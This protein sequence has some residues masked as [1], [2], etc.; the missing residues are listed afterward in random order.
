V[1]G[2]AIKT[3]EPVLI[4][5][6]STI[7]TPVSES[8]LRETKCQLAVPIK[9]SDTIVGVLDLQNDQPGTLTEED[10][11][12]MI[13]LC[14][15]IA[16]A[17]RNAELL[18]EVQKSQEA[19]QRR[20]H[21]LELSSGVSEQLTANLNLNDLLASV[22]SLI[23]GG[24]DYYHVHVYLVEEG[25][26]DLLMMEGTGEPGMIMKERGH[27]IPAGRGLVGTAAATG[28]TV[29]VPDVSKAKGWLP[30][31]LLPDTKSELS[32]PFKMGDE[33]I[34]V[35]DVQ[36]DQVGGL[37]EEDQALL[38]GLG[39]QI[40]VAV[41][42]AR[43]FGEI[44]RQVTEQT[45]EIQVFQALAENA[46]DAV[47]MADLD[48]KLF[49]ANRVW[50]NLYRYDAA[51]GEAVGTSVD[52]VWAPETCAWMKEAI[53]QQ[54]SREWRGQV[55][56]ELRDGTRLTIE[57][58]AFVVRDQNENPIAVA[59]MGRDITAARLSDELTRLVS[60]ASSQSE[61]GVELLRVVL[62]GMNVDC[63]SF[64]I[65]EGEGAPR[66]RTA[67]TVAA[68]DDRGKAVVNVDQ[69]EP[70]DSDPIHGEL[71]NARQAIIYNDLGELDEERRA[72]LEE[73]GVAAIAAL[74]LI[75][76]AG[77]VG[78]ALLLQ[79]KRD[80][81]FGDEIA[82]LTP[83]LQQVSLAVSNLIFREAQERETSAM[84]AQRTTEMQLTTEV[85]QA[86][87]SAIE[88]DDLFQRVVTLVREQF[89][90][91]HVHVYQHDPAQGILEIAAGYGEP[92]RIMREQGH[93]IQVGSGLTG[94]AAATGEPVLASDV[95]DWENW[96]PNPL[97][98][99][100]KSEVAV[101]IKMG[102]EVLGV[103]DVQDDQVGALT[104]DTQV[105]LQGLCGQIAIAIQ[106]TR[107]L[108]ETQASL[109]QTD[110]LLSLST[111]LSSLTEPQAIADA[112]AEQLMN[113]ANIERCSVTLCSEYDDQ[114]VPHTAQ[115]YALNDRDP[116]GRDAAIGHSYA[117]TAF[118]TFAKVI[119]D[120]RQVLA[121][122]DLTTDE[123]LADG[124]RTF[125]QQGGA[126]S[127]IVVP[128]VSGERVVGYFTLQDR[129][130]YTFTESE[131]ELYRGIASQSATAF[132]NALSLTEVQETLDEV[133]MLY[134]SSRAISTANTRE[135]LTETVV[136]RI[137]STNV[138]HCEIL[139]YEQ[140]DLG[141]RYVE[142]VGSWSLDG[143]APAPDTR[144][145]LKEYALTEVAEQ[146]ADKGTR[147]ITA[148]D[149]DQF[150][151]VR[152]MCVSRGIKALALVPLNVGQEYLGFLVIE[153]HKSSVFA[154]DTLRF[155]E[156]V[157]SQSAVALR[158]IQLIEQTQQQLEQLQ[159]S[160]DDA[161]RLADTVRELSSPVI[162]VWEDVLVLPLVG[163]I[164]SRRALN[165]ME[166]LLTGITEYQA[167]Q[168]IIDITGVPVM[169][170]SVANYLLQTIKAASLL[171]ARC[172]LVGISSEMAQTIVGLGLD[173]S[174]ITTYS[175]LRAGIQAALQS[176]GS[177]I[178]PLPPEE[179]EEVL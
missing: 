137:V 128:M 68:Y 44:E 41:Q 162:Q 84:L 95:K 176:T 74:P 116:R 19:A 49:Y 23:Q 86:I 91:Y 90:Y 96:L 88:L 31:P 51:K 17:I 6:R 106:N 138:D 53:G 18:K 129:E 98:P 15:Q 59:A 109:R 80:M 169:D 178:V 173:L 57:L 150:D 149:V 161:A 93:S 60:T 118:P 144:Y 164:D 43:V 28:S 119:V 50:Y 146:L 127:S 103:L 101:P 71:C 121:I 11:V 159:R 160:Y 70:F 76:E 105:L 13:G 48:G 27:R 65:Y 34:G 24:F 166:A 177:T 111:A 171:G 99:D 52:D 126:V 21:Q 152:Q 38:E 142:V 3:G 30:N 9:M 113:I 39:G 5:D 79:R 16:I 8:A 33:V 69:S 141:P 46:A 14:G 73:A 158:N 155:Y 37:A 35:L 125:L 117:L 61:L 172:M 83:I 120:E 102:D 107:L 145:R 85:A 42:N 110:L 143:E 135:D 104:L 4:S 63:G 136:Q 47:A 1:V 154:P 151:Q 54:S 147:V 132:S 45:R 97:L 165:M 174:S 7:K 75:T 122:P 89:G 67:K 130:P 10:Q 94:T 115:V 123:S 92:G 153:R 167:E 108:Q 148:N 58:T 36:D 157:A 55:P 131:I 56:Q 170:T 25:T 40:A 175:N 32:V 2:T 78:G 64:V 62:W 66:Q 100:T 26:G 112:L 72:P 134:E 12:L 124:E 81:P 163:A 140:R 168:V 20:A 82:F 87:A 77:Q 179:L 156:T 133:N 114:D 22:V 139:L 29:L